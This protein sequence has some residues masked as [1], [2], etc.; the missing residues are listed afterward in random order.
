MSIGQTLATAR[1]EAGLSVEDVSAKTRVRG[2]VIRA[3][4]NDDFSLCGGDFY[5]RGHIRTIAGIVG[6]DPAALVAEYDATFATPE[7]TPAASQVFEAEAAGPGLTKRTERRAPSWGAAAIAMVLIAVIAYAG[8]QLANRGGHH[9]NPVAVSGASTTPPSS[10][11][12]SPIVTTIGPSDTP[13]S[14]TQ[15]APQSPPT[16]AVADAGV[17]VVVRVTTERCWI[18]ATASNGEVLFQQNVEPGET[19][20]FEDPQR[21]SLTLGNAPAT[22]LVVNGVDIGPPPSQAN[23]ARVSYG[24]GDPTA[25]QG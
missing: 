18:S 20:V 14:P 16:S 13:S 25:A 9:D 12:P 7:D 24:P 1:R 5:A 11:S 8:V 4:E 2:T 10:P 19:K 17:R 3:I 15:S 21:V 23:V 6:A 22:D